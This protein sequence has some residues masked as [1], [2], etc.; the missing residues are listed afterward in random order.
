MIRFIFVCVAVTAISL[1]SLAGQFM[2]DGIAENEEMLAARNADILTVPEAE[3]DV[4]IAP[5]ESSEPSATDLNN[6]ETA[7][8]T[9]DEGNDSFGTDFTNRAPAALAEAPS[10]ETVMKPQ[11]TQDAQ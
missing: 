4:A 8:G 7:A 5:T 3:I 9:M 10:A 11:G 1:L 6:I 2:L